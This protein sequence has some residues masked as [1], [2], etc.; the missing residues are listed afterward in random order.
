M[1][2]AAPHQPTQPR[3]DSSRKAWNLPVLLASNLAAVLVLL[4]WTYAPT[5]AL[6][7]ALDTATFRALNGTLDGP[8]WWQITVAVSNNRKF[9]LVPFI[10]IAIIF[11]VFFIEGKRRQLVRRSAAAVMVTV[12]ILVLHKFVD[13]DVFQINRKS[14]TLVID[15]A[16]LV[17]EQVLGIHSKDFSEKSFPGDHTLFLMMLNVFLWFYGGRRWGLLFVPVTLIF[18]MPRLISGAHWLT[19]D[20]IGGGFILLVA[21]SWLLATPLKDWLLRWFEPPARFL[22]GRFQPDNVA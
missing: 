8:R 14:P 18:S 15:G 19:D 7:D 4:S 10:L 1:E 22:L 11:T 6:W 3:G 2:P 16:I 17:S 13:L 20:V 21:M 12:F 5:R 9:D